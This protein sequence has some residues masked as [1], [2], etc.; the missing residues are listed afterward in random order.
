LFYIYVCDEP[1]YFLN[2]A[3]V[4]YKP[5]TKTNFMA[6]DG[7]AQSQNIWPMP[8]FYFRVKIGDLEGVFQEVSGLDTET[9]VVEY[10][11]DKSPIH[12][13]IKMPGIAKFSNITLKKGI[14]DDKDGFWEIYN[15]QKLNTI[16]RQTVTI[17][18][19]DEENNITMSWKLSNAWF[20]KIS[21]TDIKSE[22]N[23]TAVETMEL[24]HEGLTILQT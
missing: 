8:K 11:A 6:D 2:A 16:K 12:S 5:T 21:G 22:S 3:D 23:E 14:F 13:T 10:R 18:L 24:A 19:M 15:A 1:H 7:S 17:S 9:Q 4:I 20:T